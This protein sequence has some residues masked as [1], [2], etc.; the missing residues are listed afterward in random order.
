MAFAV[1]ERDSELTDRGCSI[2]IERMED[3]EH[4]E[5]LELRLRIA[6]EWPLGVMHDGLRKQVDVET[7][8]RLTPSAGRFFVFRTGARRL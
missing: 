2:S 8:R 6:C 4:A 7:G 3:C 5:I 1:V